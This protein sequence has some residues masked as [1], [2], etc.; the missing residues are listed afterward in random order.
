MANLHSLTNL[1]LT[2]IPVELAELTALAGEHMLVARALFL[3]PPCSPCLFQ[4]HLHLVLFTMP[5]PPPCLPPYFHLT[6]FS[7][8]PSTPPCS[9]LPSLPLSIPPCLGLQLKSLLLP[10]RNVFFDQHLEIVAGDFLLVDYH[11]T[12]VC[13]HAS[14][15]TSSQSTCISGNHLIYMHL[16]PAL[17][18]S[19]VLSLSLSTSVNLFYSYLYP[20]LSEYQA[21]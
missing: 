9:P 14:L 6:L 10:D 12:I 5:P 18:V 19:L 16:C 11:L 4:T 21:W 1:S 7:M 3:H 17:L 13:L 15:S 8:P 20:S 2:G